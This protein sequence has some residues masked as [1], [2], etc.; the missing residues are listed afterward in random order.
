M[1]PSELSTGPARRKAVELSAFFERLRQV[2]DDRELSQ[3]DLAREL[4]VGVATVS[5]WFTRGR[6]PNG[7]VMLRLPGALRVN[8]HW[9]L[10]GEG[11]REREQAPDGDPYL[12]GACDAIERLRQALDDASR[13]F[14][15][16]AM[17]A[18]EPPAGGEP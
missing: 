14:G 12:R 3:A 18:A 17:P 10:T 4:G 7:D 16:N 1:L 6:V 13:R 2:L 9:L 5:E 15:A 8:G 11:P